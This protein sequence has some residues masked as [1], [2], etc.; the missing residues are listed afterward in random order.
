MGNTVAQ[1][2]KHA[3]YKFAKTQ[4]S[5]LPDVVQEKLKAGVRDK[6]VANTENSST[7]GFA[8]DRN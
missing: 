6:N 5:M 7:F 4:F 8:P 2:S 3:L 1:L